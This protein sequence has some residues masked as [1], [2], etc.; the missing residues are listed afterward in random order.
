MEATLR[1][2]ASR[3]LKLIFFTPVGWLRQGPFIR[4]EKHSKLSTSFY[5]LRNPS[6]MQNNIA[7]F[8]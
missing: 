7:Q 8:Q 6:L 2:D 1:W 5:P 4:E 3:E